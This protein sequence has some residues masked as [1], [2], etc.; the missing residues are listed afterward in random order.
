MAVQIGIVKSL[1]GQVTATAADGSIRTLQA[2]DRVYANE[3]ISTGPDGAIEIE[4]EDG[5]VM[6]LGRS[7]QAT[8]DSEL[9]DPQTAVAESDEPVDDDIA[10]IQQALLEGEDPTEAGEAT[11][12]GAGVAGGN[13]G[14]E[15]VFVDYLNPEVTPTAGFDTIGVTNEYDLPE[16]DLIILDEEDGAPSAGGT[17]VFVDEDDLDG[18]DSFSAIIAA[19]QLDTTFS[20]SFPNKSGN[21]DEE[22]G[23]DLPPNSST[24][25]SG[26]LNASFGPDGPGNAGF[27]RPR[28]SHRI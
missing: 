17:E 22:P 5:S 21:N 6:D 27:N 26:S 7:S 12:A 2:G 20:I 11:A 25:Q 19:F 4:F 1:V 10:A 16:E 28:R 24:T 3:L 14:H 9:Y 18:D 23:D 8:L 15:A 13:E